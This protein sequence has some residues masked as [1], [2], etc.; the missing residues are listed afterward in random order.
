MGHL[1]SGVILSTVRLA[2]DLN[3]QLGY[4]LFPLKGCHGYLGIEC[5]AV[6]LPCLLHTVAPIAE[7]GA[8]PVADDR[9]SCSF[10]SAAPSD[11]ARSWP[12]LRRLVHEGWAEIESRK[13]TNFQ[14]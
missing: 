3:Y 5:R 6:L 4:G 13:R 7:V 2:A 1:T 11:K 8:P 12:D 14:T 10:A 9:Q